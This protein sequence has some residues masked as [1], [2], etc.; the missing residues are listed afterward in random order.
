M[1]NGACNRGAVALEIGRDLSG[2]IVCH[3]SI[4]RRAT[5]S[6][7]IAVVVVDNAHSAGYVAKN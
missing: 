6:N 3:C 2:V 4:C 5:G 7:G 1:A